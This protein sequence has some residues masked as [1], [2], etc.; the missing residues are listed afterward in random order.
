MANMML[1]CACG[2]VQGEMKN[3]SPKSGIRVVCY[4][5]ACQQFQKHLSCDDK[6]LNEHG[7]TELYQTAPAQIS[8]TSGQEKIACL[9]ITS[10]GPFRWY[11]SCC[12][13]PIGNTMKASI[14]FVGVIQSFIDADETTRQEVMGSVRCEAQTQYAYDSLPKEIK[15]VGFP[16]NITLKIM[17]KILSWKIKGLAQPSPFFDSDGKA[18]SKPKLIG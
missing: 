9:R 4:C 10:K 12:N 5:D 11:A 3:V 7:G 17:S 6:Y 1:K 18:I 2:S 8:I 16:L 14:P 13:T 15:R